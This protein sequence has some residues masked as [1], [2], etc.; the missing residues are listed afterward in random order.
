MCVYAIA[1]LCNQ[2]C[3]FKNSPPRSRHSGG[4]S[5]QSTPLRLPLPPA[6]WNRVRCSSFNHSSWPLHPAI[7]S[8]VDIRKQETYPSKDAKRWQ[9]NDHFTTSQEKTNKCM[10]TPRLFVGGGRGCR[11]VCSYG[12]RSWPRGFVAVKE[13]KE[14]GP[15]LKASWIK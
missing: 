6:S 13:W 14:S 4:Q 12:H 2:I 3:M 9:K 8:S 5:W 15:D 1:C 11:S 10:I 7:T